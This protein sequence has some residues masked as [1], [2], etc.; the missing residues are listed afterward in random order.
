LAVLAPNQ[1]SD[2]LHD[3]KTRVLRVL[4]LGKYFHPDRGGIESVVKDIVQGTVRAGC[5]VTVLCLGRV[6]DLRE[7]H[8]CAARV[9]RA[10]IWRVVASQPLG[11]KYF[12]ESLRRAR[13]FD[14]V[15]VHT[16][17][18]LA[19]LAIVLAQVRGKVIVHWHA[20]VVNHG[21][22]GMLLRPLE[23]LMLRRA[24]AVVATSQAYADTAPRLH[25]FKHKVHIV[26][27]GVA[28]PK[29]S[30]EDRERGSRVGDRFAVLDDVPLILAVGRLVPYKGFD[31]LID[32]ARE[33]QCD[34]RI[35]IVGDGE[36]R[37][38]LEA[39]VRD[40]HLSDKVILAGR[41]DDEALSAAFQR[42]AVFCLPSR[43]RAEASRR[44]SVSCFWR[45]WRTV[46]RLS[47]RTLLV[48]A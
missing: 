38:E 30:N 47:Q 33:L 32:A 29:K 2:V 17:N 44:R 23:W 37:S 5:D 14:I 42:A 16:P 22:L 40:L 10:P 46:C 26:P 45:R 13:D 36:C 35:L 34:C 1:S 39:R 7:E 21:L 25:A 43:T 12:R 48:P 11:W 15:Q 18:M 9:V 27:I 31:V 3:A 4:H 6:D 28:D 24:D 20:D 8:F 19:A 41:L